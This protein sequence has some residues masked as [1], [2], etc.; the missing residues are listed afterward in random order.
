MNLN[1]NWWVFLIFT[2][3]LL[4]WQITCHCTKLKQYDGQ[5]EQRKEYKRRLR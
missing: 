1:R 2:I 4:A 3:L 5:E